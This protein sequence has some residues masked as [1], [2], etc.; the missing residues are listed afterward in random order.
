MGAPLAPPVAAQQTSQTKNPVVVLDTSCGPITIELYPDKAPITV[1]N[2][3]KYVDDGF[4]NNLLIHRVVP[5]FVI[6]GGGVND[7][8][9]EKPPTHGSIKNE[10]GNGLA[11]K[12]GFVAM[13]RTSDPNSATCQFFIDLKDND[14]LDTMRYAVFGKVI[15]GMDAVDSIARVARTTREGMSDVPVEPV[16]IKSARRRKG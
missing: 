9:E 10:S 5:D 12:R 2:F 6:Q 1:E 3:L 11:N 7:K 15:D 4:Y 13:A 8:M 14:R 16:Y